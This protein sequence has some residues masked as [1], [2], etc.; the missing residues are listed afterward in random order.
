[1]K[2]DLITLAQK[3]RAAHTH[4]TSFRMPMLTVNQWNQLSTLLG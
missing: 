4:G 1:M 2:L 3:V